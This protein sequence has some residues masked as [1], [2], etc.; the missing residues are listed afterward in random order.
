MSANSLRI[1]VNELFELCGTV[2]IIEHMTNT[3][4][5][6][7]VKNGMD[8]AIATRIRDGARSRMGARF[9][10]R[11]SS[12]IIECGLDEDACDAALAFYKGPGA[13]FMAIC[14]SPQWLSQIQA[15]AMEEARAAVEIVNKEMGHA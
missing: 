6:E 4:V 9:I 12:M 3:M 14:Q 13:K 5:P 7:L 11:I 15:V 8:E 1:K 2:K 10:T